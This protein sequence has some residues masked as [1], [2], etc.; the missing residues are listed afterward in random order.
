MGA[1]V[2]TN[3]I[4]F[5]KTGPTKQIWYGEVEGK[6]TKK[7]TIQDSNFDEVYQKSQ[8]REMSENS[9]MVTYE[10]VASKRCSLLPRNPNKADDSVVPEPKELTHSIHNTQSSV[11]NMLDE[12]VT[13]AGSDKLE[14]EEIKS[15]SLNEIADFFND[16]DW[17]EKKDQSADGIRLVQTGNVGIIE[18]KDKDDKKYITEETFKRLNCKEVFAGDILISRLPK[19][20]GRACMVPDLGYR[21][22]TAVDCTIFRPKKDYSPKYLNFLINSP[23]ALFQ[24]DEYLTGSSRKRISRSNLEKIKLPIPYKNGLPDKKTQEKIAEKLEKIQQKKREIEGKFILQASDLDKL[25]RSFL[26]LAFQG[27]L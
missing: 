3:L 11:N 24:V 20:V 6:F 22:I 10:Q 27:K 13:F 1:G 4:F 23:D 2:K 7:K 26:H 9:W 19:P 12:M 16:G 17:I 25:G 21:L 8:K 14:I 5:D 18:F 15:Q